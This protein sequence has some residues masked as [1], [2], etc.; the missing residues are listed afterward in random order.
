MLSESTA[1]GITTR[2]ISIANAEVFIYLSN[3]FIEWICHG[4][5]VHFVQNA[6]HAFLFVLKLTMNDINLGFWET[7]H[8][9]LP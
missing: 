8:L 4:C 6:C 9:P 7:A 3:L 1:K 5:L 2:K